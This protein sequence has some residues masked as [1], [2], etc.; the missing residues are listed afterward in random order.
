MG[1]A[2]KDQETQEHRQYEA[3]KAKAESDGQKL[4][5]NCGKQFPHVDG[6]LLCEECYY[7]LLE[8]F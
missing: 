3:R 8:K 6:E 2:K 4:C 7:K 5:E 1:Q